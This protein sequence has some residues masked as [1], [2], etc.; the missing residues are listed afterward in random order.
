VWRRV[1]AARR[2]R[3]AQPGS[4]RKR[5]CA[6]P[7][8][9]WR[10]SASTSART[11][12]ANTSACAGAASTNSRSIWVDC[13]RKPRRAR[14]FVTQ[15]L[16]ARLGAR[17]KAVRIRRHRGLAAGGKKF[18]QQLRRGEIARSKAPRP[19]LSAA[20]S[21]C[22]IC[23]NGSPRSV[24]VALRQRSTS[25]MTPGAIARGSNPAR[26]SED[27]PEPEAPIS[28]KK[29]RLPQL[30]NGAGN[31]GLAPE[32]TTARMPRFEGCKPA[33]RASL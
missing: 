9:R 23:N 30:C 14:C 12:V 33:K 5:R 3:P 6:A 2:G 18:G 8:P 4:V 11:S 26:R 21:A 7:P 25:G 28:S 22:A 29:R 10:G 27:L 32:K 17:A 13:E 15:C 24:T 19:V 31:G 1:P 20:N 16:R